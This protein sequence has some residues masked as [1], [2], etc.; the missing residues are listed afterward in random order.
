MRFATWASMS[1]ESV[2]TRKGMKLGANIPAASSKHEGR[3]TRTHVGHSLTCWT[4]GSLGDP[5]SQNGADGAPRRRQP[6][7]TVQRGMA[8]PSH[9]GTCRQS[10]TL[11]CS[12]FIIALF[13]GRKY[14]K[15]T[16][17]ILDRPRDEADVNP[18][19]GPSSSYFFQSSFRC[20]NSL[21]RHRHRKQFDTGGT[22]SSAKQISTSLWHKAQRGFPH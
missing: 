17:T 22:N 3:W 13:R 14:R 15:L 8:V 2:W 10:C 18:E 1:S 9:V 11:S 20:S 12:I 19:I 4:E 6:A 7:H 21:Y 16:S 5:G